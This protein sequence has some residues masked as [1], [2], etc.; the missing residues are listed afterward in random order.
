MSF[1]NKYIVYQTGS[2]KG[3]VI[4]NE[5]V[6]VKKYYYVRREIKGKPKYLHIVNGEASFSDSASAT[7]LSEEE[8]NKYANILGVKYG[9]KASVYPSTIKLS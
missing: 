4:I 6:K 7:S 8:A 2:V 1:K 9:I 3:E 5:D